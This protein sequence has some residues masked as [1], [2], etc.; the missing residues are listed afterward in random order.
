[1]TWQNIKSAPKD[2]TKVIF[3]GKWLPYDILEGG[4]DAYAL[5]TWSSFSSSA[6]EENCEWITETAI[7]GPIDVDRYNVEW[8]HY[9]LLP[10]PPEDI[11]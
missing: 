3:Y 2:G 7:G 6:P 5:A 9:Q 8:T 11:S 10:D 4:E 1:M